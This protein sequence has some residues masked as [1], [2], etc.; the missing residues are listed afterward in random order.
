[1]TVRRVNKFLFVYAAHRLQSSKH[2]KGFLHCQ[3]SVALFIERTGVLGFLHF[4]MIPGILQFLII[5]S[6]FLFFYPIDSLNW[7]TQRLIL[8]SKHPFPFCFSHSFLPE[9]CAGSQ[10]VPCQHLQ[11]I[12]G[13][14]AKYFG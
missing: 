9:Q 11:G 5:P 8:Y 4:S 13:S 12:L 3:F 14:P 1:M 6:L 10:T 2:V 7:S